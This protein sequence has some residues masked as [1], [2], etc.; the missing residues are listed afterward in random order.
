M[1]LGM[2]IAVPAGAAA[3]TVAA[4]AP[5]QARVVGAIVPRA[6]GEP[7]RIIGSPGDSSG[8]P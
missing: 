1:G 6:G 8:A 7:S 4:L 3:D 2:I 5:W